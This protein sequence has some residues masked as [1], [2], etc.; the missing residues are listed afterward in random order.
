MLLSDHNP[1]TMTINLPTTHTRSNICRLDNSLLKDPEIERTISKSL[2]HYFT[3]NTL[4]DSSAATI[5]AVHKCV[6]RGELISLAAKRLK[7]RKAC[8]DELTKRIYTLDQKH[9]A[10]LAANALSE[11]MQ[12]GTN[13]WESYTKRQNLNMPLPRKYFTNGVTN[14]GEC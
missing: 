8:I 7:L 9:K 4:G 11:L 14:L 6:I 10:S 2:S 13:C 3:D 5:W 12:P 1:I